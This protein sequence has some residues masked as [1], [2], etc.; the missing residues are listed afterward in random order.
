MASV[1]C[2]CAGSHSKGCGCFSQAFI[3][4][5]HVNFFCILS[6][7]GKDPRLFETQLK[8][9]GKYH[10]CNIHSW[11]NSKCDFEFHSL[12]SCTCGDNVQ[13]EGKEYRTK[14]TLTCPFHALAYEIECFNRAKEADSIIHPELGRG[15]EASHNILVR[16]RSK[17]LQLHRLHYITKT[18]IGLCQANISWMVKKNSPSYRYHWLL[19]L[20]KRLNLPVLDMPMHRMT[21][22]LLRLWSP[23]SSVVNVAAPITTDQPMATHLLNK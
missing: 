2:H 19:D 1:T 17:D 10:A 16:F 13:C 3:T 4:Q 9:L 5:A 15:H 7:S 11:S 14:H 6:Q 22:V 20:F 21:L 12:K 18:N 8:L 23:T